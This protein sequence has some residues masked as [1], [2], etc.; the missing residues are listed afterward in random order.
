MT[1]TALEIGLMN[2]DQGIERGLCRRQLCVQADGLGLEVVDLPRL[3]ALEVANIMPERIDLLLMWWTIK[4]PVEWWLISF[5]SLLEVRFWMIDGL[6]DLSSCDP[7][8]GCGG[9]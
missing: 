8:R 9:M 7:G 5:G 2:L 3:I 6:V 4:T 1:F